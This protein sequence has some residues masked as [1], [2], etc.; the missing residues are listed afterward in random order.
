MYIYIYIKFGHQYSIG[1]KIWF[2]QDHI[3]GVSTQRTYSV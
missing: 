1:L 2:I 3:V